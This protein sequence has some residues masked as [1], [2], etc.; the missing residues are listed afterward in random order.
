LHDKNATAN[1]KFCI[2]PCTLRKFIDI[3]G[4]HAS[5]NGA[6]LNTVAL[7]S[8][9]PLHAARAYPPPSHGRLI[10]FE[11]RDQPMFTNEFFTAIAKE[12]PG[13]LDIF[14]RYFYELATH[15]LS[16]LSNLL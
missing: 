3:A 2:H 8:A 11:R 12:I 6:T 1:S 5:F 10:F 16:I 13:F 7:F 4:F 15:G 9:N 14:V